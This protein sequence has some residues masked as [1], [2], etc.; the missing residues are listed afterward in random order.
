MRLVEDV[1]DTVATFDGRIGYAQM[2]DGCFE[3]SFRHLDAKSRLTICAQATK[4]GGV[5]VVAAADGS[6]FGEGDLVYEGQFDAKVVRYRVSTW[7]ALWYREMVIHP[8]M[9]E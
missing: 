2:A 8:S 1:V 9:P 4:T 7:L 6:A 3:V 5:S